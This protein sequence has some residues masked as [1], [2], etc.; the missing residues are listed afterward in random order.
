MTK[1]L[2]TAF[3]ADQHIEQWQQR[4]MNIVDHETAKRYMN[5]ISYY[6]LSAYT[7][8]FQ[9]DNFDHH[10]KPDTKFEH[11][12]DLYRFDRE[13]R[14]LVMDAIECI[15]VAIRSN[16][17]NI[18]ALQYG[19]HWYMDETHFKRHYAH[20]NL[21]A[22]IEK[23]YTY[24]YSP[25]RLAPGWI[26]VELLSFGQLLNLYKNLQRERDR[27][28]IAGGLNTYSVLLCPWMQQIWAVR[29]ICAHHSR[30]W[31]RQFEN[32]HKLSQKIPKQ[33][34]ILP[35]KQTDPD[36]YPNKRLYP[37]LVVFE[38]LLQTINKDS[39]WHLRFFRLIQQ[40]P[41]VSIREMGMPDDWYQDPFWRITFNQ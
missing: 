32:T 30:L 19:S 22:Y 17:T 1:Y 36:I 41:D 18:M 9:N 39:K 25:P 37:L 31:N 11:I 2:K 3:T 20:K 29:K 23:Q 24:R 14:L 40:H 21:V 10:F 8:H 5:V 38:Y 12:V 35:I 27:N 4:G 6:R 7:Q 15:E 16:I 13:L 34:V 28:A 33:W 26:V